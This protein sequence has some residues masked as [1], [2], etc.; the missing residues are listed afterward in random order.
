MP[1]TMIRDCVICHKSFCIKGA[2]SLYCSDSCKLLSRKKTCE[3][4]GKEFCSIARRRF[5]SPSCSSSRVRKPKA[6]LSNCL[7]CGK[8]FQTNY[9][10]KRKYCSRACS[11][12][13]NSGE[14]Q[15]QSTYGNRRGMTRAESIWNIVPAGRCRIFRRMKL[16]C[17]RCDWNKSNCDLHHIKGRKINNPH[18]QDNLCYLCPNCHREA[19]RGLIPINELIPFSVQV[20]MKWKEFYYA[21]N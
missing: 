12:I 8:E 6:N 9:T 2:G 18:S 10:T 19:G 15:R 14:K 20:G 1:H 16:P 3:T 11:A 13:I 7:L 21:S 17:S 4:C 5:C